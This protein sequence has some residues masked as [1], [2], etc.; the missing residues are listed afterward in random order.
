MNNSDTYTEADS[1]NNSKIDPIIQAFN[2]SKK[3]IQIINKNFKKFDSKFENLEKNKPICLCYYLLNLILNIIV[4]FFNFCLISFLVWILFS[5]LYPR[6]RYINYAPSK[7]LLWKC[8][9][10]DLTIPTISNPY[11]NQKCNL[12]YIQCEKYNT[13]IY[14]NSYN[15]RLFNNYSSLVN[16]GL[17]DQYNC[18]VYKS[19]IYINN[20]LNNYIVL[21]TYTTYLNNTFYFNV[22][23]NCFYNDINLGNTTYQ[24]N[25]KIDKFINNYYDNRY[26]SP[27]IDDFSKKCTSELQNYFLK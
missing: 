4:V 11:F 8:Y 24:V 25:N 6:I 2:L 13:T 21:K 7:N 15:T 10:K 19:N 14:K 18:L 12:N 16:Y 26:F 27:I 9:N 1:N 17:I 23:L 20:Y 3:Q 22:D 5:I